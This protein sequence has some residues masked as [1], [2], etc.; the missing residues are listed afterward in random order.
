MTVNHIFEKHILAKDENTHK[1]SWNAK[2]EREK[3]PPLQ[4]KQL[5]VGTVSCWRISEAQLICKIIRNEAAGSDYHCDLGVYLSFDRKSVQMNSPTYMPPVRQ[6][7]NADLHT[8]LSLVK[9][10]LVI[11]R[12]RMKGGDVTSH[13]ILPCEKQSLNDC[14]NGEESLSKIGKD[15]RNNDLDWN[16]MGNKWGM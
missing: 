10:Y 9:G 3:Q 12:Y 2:R 8:E 14:L 1:C 15:Q 16:V 7:A 13:Q 4:P 5:S 11:Q 6:C